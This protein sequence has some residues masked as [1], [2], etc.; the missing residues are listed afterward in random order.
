MESFQV[1]S[2][3]FFAHC[4]FLFVFLS[5]YFFDVVIFC[6]VAQVK[7]CLPQFIQSSFS[8]QFWE[9]QFCP[10][11]CRH[12]CDTP[13]AAFFSGSFTHNV[14]VVVD[15]REDSICLC[16]CCIFHQFRVNTFQTDCASAVV[17]SVLVAVSFPLLNFSYFFIWHILCLCFQACQVKVVDNNFARTC[18]VT[19]LCKDICK[20]VTFDTSFNQNFLAWLYIDTYYC[21]HSGIFANHFFIHNSLSLCFIRDRCPYLTYKCMCTIVQQSD[22]F[23]KG[24][25]LFFDEASRTII[26]R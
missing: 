6:D 12:H 24:I 19:F 23:F 7:N 8:V 16:F 18:F 4:L 17:Q 11:I 22:W 10:F 20:L 26:N 5:P 13:L 25:C 3:H 2:I 21:Q 1:K 14:S 15:V 9:H